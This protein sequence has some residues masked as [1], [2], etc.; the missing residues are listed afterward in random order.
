[1]KKFINWILDQLFP[2]PDIE[3]EWTIIMMR[4]LLEKGK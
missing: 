2:L 3:G 4:R 1:M